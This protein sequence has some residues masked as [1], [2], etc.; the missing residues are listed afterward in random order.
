VPDAALDPERARLATARDGPRPSREQGAE[1]REHFVPWHRWGTYLA[2]RQWATVREDY[3]PDGDAWEFFPHDHA[4]S[5]VYRWGEDGLLGLCDDQMRLC[6][7][8]AL[9]N[10]R[11]PFLK[12][13]LFGLTGPQGNHGEDVKEY[14]FYL[15][16]TPTHSSM[17]ALYKYP[18]RAFPYAELV[19]RNASRDRDEPEFELLDS[20][21]FDDD[22]YFD[23]L[24]EYAKLDPTDIFARIS[25]TNRGPDAAVLH[26]LPTLWFRNTW[27]WGLDERR[28][29][30]YA[31]Q[32]GLVRAEHP[33]LGDYWLAC[34]GAPRLLFTENETNTLRLWGAP[35]R[36]AYVKDGIDDAVVN[37]R[38]EAV[39]PEQVGTKVAAQYVFDLQPGETRRVVLRLSATHQTQ[40]MRVADEVFACRQA[41]ADRFYATVFGFERLSADARHVQRQA[42]AGLLWTKQV[43][44][45]DIARW[46]AGDP[47]GPP[48]PNEHTRGRNAAWW[49]F[50]TVHVLSV[51]DTWEYPWFAAWDLAFHC[52]PLALL[53]PEFAKDQLS[54]MLREWYMHP[55]GQLPAY[56]WAFD[57]VNPPVHAWAVW[58]VYEIEKQIAGI[59]DRSFLESAFHKLLLNF[60]WWVNRKDPD[61]LNVFQGG[62][63]GLDNIGVFDRSVELP[64]GGHLEQSDGTAWMGMYC[65][66]MLVIALELARDNNT[67]E[68]IANKFFQHFLYVASAMNNVGGKG[69]ALWD[70]DDEF[71]YD[72]LHVPGGETRSLRVRS[73]VGLIPLLA[74][75]TI[76]P[77]LLEQVPSFRARLE[78]FLANRPQLASLVSRWFEPG[79]GERRLLALVRGHR[80]KRLLARMLDPD[81]FLSEF[82]VRSVSKYHLQRPYVL[83][84]GGARH[85]VE[86]E[87]GES[88]TNLFG[89]N[90]NWRGPVWLPINFLLIEALRRFHHYYGDDFVVE[91][92]TGSGRL[93]TLDA[94]ATD[95]AERLTRLFLV[96]ADGSRPVFGGV[97]LLRTEHWRDCVPF[98]EYFHG[99]TGAG[100]GA[101]HQTGWTALVAQL[102]AYG[103]QS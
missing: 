102:L 97:P 96:A 47:A 24:V 9:W 62:F 71:F 6:F 16:G 83:E 26:V 67:Y 63:L 90:S 36:S 87:P 89:G 25:T 21:V 12:E 2:E 20:G 50:N 101:S 19:A 11:D 10:T 95:L 93:L 40:P 103:G 4:R 99:D 44:I 59:A 31:V 77:E 75:E 18:Q 38:I 51:P 53:D 66:N 43:Y 60:T 30:L 22:R 29:A 64:G 82:G 98:Y 56:E 8:L 92:P 70:D 72:V 46:L 1:H 45:W 27:A 74:V 52:V 94:I 61:G 3:S 33:V 55:N 68:E 84:L 78:W 34:D 80:M 79:L 32:D 7:A 5:R 14:Y 17:R 86:Y 35:N 73:L 23:V 57:D 91:C 69:F 42:F 81:E 65:L 58:R 76:E 48:P 54:I 100:L 41:E 13:R 88:R 49:H 15:D 28:P 85:M 39:N 37:G